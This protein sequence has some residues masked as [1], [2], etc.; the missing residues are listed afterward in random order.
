MP[1]R[2]APRKFMAHKQVVDTAKA[3]A[4]EVWESEMGGN[5]ELYA[6]WKSQCAEQGLTLEQGRE[7]FVELLYPKL[8]EPARATLARMLAN[9]TLSHLHEA[10]YD[11]LQKDYLFRDGRQ[12]RGREMLEVSK[13][14]EVRTRK[15][16]L[17]RAH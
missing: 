8:I 11:A 7:L 2:E 1:K 9:P 6:H 17:Q 15:S 10:I 5:N 12:G 16:P 13:D 14:G 4:L 3:M